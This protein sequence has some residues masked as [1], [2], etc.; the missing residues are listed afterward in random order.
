MSTATRVAAGTSS[1][2]SFQHLSRQLGI[3]EVDAGQVAARSAK[4]GDKTKP[5]GVFSGEEDNGDRRGYRLGRQHHGGASG[6]GN[7][8]ALPADQFG[9]PQRQSTGWIL[10]PPEE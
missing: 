2:K 10:G 4:A 8:R 6:C 7:H 3:E 1:R 5:D 9:C